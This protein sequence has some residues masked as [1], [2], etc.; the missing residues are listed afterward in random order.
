MGLVGCLTWLGKCRESLP[1]VVSVRTV[2]SLV[3][4]AS[5]ICKGD[6][7]LARRL[8]VPGHHPHEWRHGKRAISPETVGLLA[9]VLHLDGDEA[10]RL[11]V[12]AVIENPKNREKA[13][14]LRRAFFVC[15][16][17]GVA[18]FCGAETTEARGKTLQAAS[19]PLDIL[20]I[21]SSLNLHCGV[22]C[23]ARLLGRLRLLAAAVCRS[24]LNGLTGR[25]PR[26]VY[27]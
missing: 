3:D 22:S 6:A 9:E 2:L 7:A 15:W 19:K 12:M 14:V 5:E 10:R 13:G 8:G 21:T 26:T 24:T 25:D 27:R 20:S 18:V 16:V 1:K 17:I 4:E 23:V 11:A